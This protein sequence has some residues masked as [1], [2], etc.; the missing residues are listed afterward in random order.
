MAFRGLAQA[1]TAAPR[2]AWARP[3]IEE[4]E[5]NKSSAPPTRRRLDAWT[6]EVGVEPPPQPRPIARPPVSLP[7]D[8]AFDVSPSTAS[9]SLAGT[10]RGIQPGRFAPPSN[11]RKGGMFSNIVDTT[12]TKPVAVEDLVHRG[13]RAGKAFG[14]NDP[15]RAAVKTTAV[16][17]RQSEAWQRSYAR[18]RRTG[19][20]KQSQSERPGLA[21]L[22]S[23]SAAK[24]PATHAHSVERRQEDVALPMSTGAHDLN[25]AEPAAFEMTVAPVSPPQETDVHGGW[26]E[27][28]Q[29]QDESRYLTVNLEEVRQNAY[30][31]NAIPLWQPAPCESQIQPRVDAMMC[32]EDVALASPWASVSREAPCSGESPASAEQFEGP[33]CLVPRKELHDR[34]PGDYVYL[35]NVVASLPPCSQSDA[36]SELPTEALVECKFWHRRGASWENRDS[37]RGSIDATGKDWSTE[38][39]KPDELRPL[40]VSAGVAQAESPVQEQ[41]PVVGSE[42]DAAQRN[43]QMQ[44]QRLAAMRSAASPE[45]RGP[46]AEDED[47]H[48][49]WAH[50]D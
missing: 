19:Q 36:S 48:L 47:L 35:G 20:P 29:L 12:P 41:P 16:D 33:V 25:R 26:E 1:S 42:R 32:W 13:S 10:C 40:D 39:A 3:A 4:I 17:F 22:G 43:I 2:L 11:S 49:P 34:H 18:R 7:S 14:S 24:C 50:E 44:L 30:G 27:R 15:A 5:D 9:S 37:N 45:L 6:D 21:D 8:L 38:V 31:S 46:S 28:A 23:V